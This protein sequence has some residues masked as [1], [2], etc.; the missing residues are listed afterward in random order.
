MTKVGGLT[1]AYKEYECGRDG[2]RGMEMYEKT[3]LQLDVKKFSLALVSR[4]VTK[5]K[6]AGILE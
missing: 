1:Y 6:I 5:G 3:H 4:R 2:R